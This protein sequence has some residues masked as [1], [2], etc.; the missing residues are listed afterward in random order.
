[1]KRCPNCQHEVKNED[2]VCPY[3]GHVLSEEPRVI[4][5]SL[6]IWPVIVLAISMAFL[7]FYQPQNAIMTSIPKKGSTIGEVKETREY[8]KVMSFNSYATFSNYFTNGEDLMKDALSF[9]EKL[10]VFLK[11]QAY[12]YQRSESVSLYSHQL[13]ETTTQYD[14]FSESGKVILIYHEDNLKNESLWITM[15]IEGE[16]FTDLNFIQDEKHPF[17]ALFK[18]FSGIDFSKSIYVSSLARFQNLSEDFEKYQGHIGHYGIGVQEES[19]KIM[20]YPLY[21][22]EGYQSQFSFKIK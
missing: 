17:Y 21:D 11:E 16:T 12:R 1:M 18:Y 3:C 20:I 14:I 22:Q 19:F 9:E 7:Y 4:R 6:P 13:V 8:D 5:I 2:R 15:E 10:D